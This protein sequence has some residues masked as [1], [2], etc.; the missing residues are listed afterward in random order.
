MLADSI[1]M[2]RQNGVKSRR[3]QMLFELAE[4]SSFPEFEFT[5][6]YSIWHLTYSTGQKKPNR[7]R[8]AEHVLKVFCFA[9]PKRSSSISV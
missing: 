7:E 1:L 2:T 8:C 3:N 9:F 6:F 5:G 4:S